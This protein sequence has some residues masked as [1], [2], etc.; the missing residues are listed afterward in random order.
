AGE[1]HPQPVVRHRSRGGRRLLRLGVRELPHRQR[2]PLHRS[3]AAAG[4]HGDDGRVRARRTALRRH[5]RRAGVHLQRG[6]LL[7]SRLRGPGR[8][9]LLLGPPVRGRR[10][11]AVRLAEGSLRPVLAGGAGGHGRGLRRPGPGAR[12]AGDAGD[13][14]HAQARRRRPARRRRRRAG[15]L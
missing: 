5:Q 13:V 14:R 11:G 6:R 7:P 1:D 8:R 10:G 4:G 2:R 3:R 15:D 12:R 9:R